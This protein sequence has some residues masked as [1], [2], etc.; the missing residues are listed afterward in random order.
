[1][2]SML[3]HDYMH[4]VC[5][6]VTRRLL[7]CG[8]S[9]FA[10]LG[11]ACCPGNNSGVRNTFIFQ[12]SDFGKLYVQCVWPY[13][14]QWWYKKKKTWLMSGKHFWV[15]EPIFFWVK[16]PNYIKV[17]GP[18]MAYATHLKWELWSHVFVFLQSEWH[19]GN[20]SSHTVKTIKIFHT[21][22]T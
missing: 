22:R 3:P 2:V 13:T 21:I 12:M 20:V 19:T 7:Y 1:M 16:M 18:I 17:G 9:A 10:G 14:S 8:Q 5:L 6:G 11:A 4:F 15:S